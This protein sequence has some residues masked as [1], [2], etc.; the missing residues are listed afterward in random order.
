MGEE[1]HEA[2]VTGL[3]LDKTVTADF[4]VF[5]IAAIGHH[6]MQL[7]SISETKGPIR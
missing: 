2:T 3:G 4:G 1:S 5:K 7:E 6:R